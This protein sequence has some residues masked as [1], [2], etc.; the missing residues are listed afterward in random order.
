MYYVTGGKNQTGQTRDPKD[1]TVLVCFVGGV[2]YS[3]IAAL[4]FLGHLTGK[5]VR[6]F[7]SVCIQ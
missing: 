5:R 7:L 3:E 6:I 4:R 2:T 1:Q